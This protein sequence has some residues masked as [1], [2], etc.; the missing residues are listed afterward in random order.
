MSSALVFVRVLFLYFRS[1]LIKS[2]KSWILEQVEQKMY[3]SSKQGLLLF[4]S[5]ILSS[6]T[7]HLY[8]QKNHV[9]FFF[10]PRNTATRVSNKNNF[11]NTRDFVNLVKKRSTF[12]EALILIL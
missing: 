1:V 8:T 9:Y 12:E 2:E 7:L 6:L 3:L 5:V 4:S 10:N 11:L